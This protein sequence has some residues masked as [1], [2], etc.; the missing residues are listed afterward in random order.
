MATPDDGLDDIRHRLDHVRAPLADVERWLTS[1]RP[2]TVHAAVLHLGDRLQACA[3]P[4]SPLIAALPADLGALPA[5]S[6]IA[7]A[8]RALAGAPIAVPTAAPDAP[9]EVRLA[10]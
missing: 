5:E 9:I 2:A 3:E 6:Q 4:L 8:E 10:W 1:P 7:L